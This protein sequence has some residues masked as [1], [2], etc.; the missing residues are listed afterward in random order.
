MHATPQ[1]VQKST[2]GHKQLAPRWVRSGLQAFDFVAPTLAQRVV[3]RLY[4][5]PGRL[6]VT[7]EQRAILERGDRFELDVGGI[8]VAGRQWG[9]GPR[10]VWLVHGWGGH[11]GQMTAL[12]EPL[13]AQGFRVIGFDWPGHGASGGD[14]SSLLHALRA[15]QHLERF[16]GPPSA[17]VAHSFGAA[18]TLLAVGSGLACERIVLLAPV[19]RL[20]PYVERFTLALGMSEARQRAFIERAE[21]W[22]EAPFADFEPLRFTPSLSVP[23]LVLHSRDDREVELS[24]GEL[25]A[26]TWGAG[27]QLVVKDGLG[28]RRLLRDSGCIDAAVQF[29]GA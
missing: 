11:L 10:S 24:E 3:Q 26:A 25:L 27:A 12:V 13:V 8:A 17:V 1:P 15:L 7:P 20:K 4:F 16:V 14:L 23:V 9:R 6:R 18:A 5:K 22:L 2:T 28:H 19:A 29:L 21:A